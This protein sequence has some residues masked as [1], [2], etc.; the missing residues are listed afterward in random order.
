[1]TPRGLAQVFFFRDVAVPTTATL[2]VDRATSDLK[3]D[4]TGW[5]PKRAL[6]AS[7]SMTAEAA[8]SIGQ[9]LIDLGNKAAAT[10][11]GARTA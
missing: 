6:V 11:E 4:M 8:I 5:V 10:R 3:S 2:E 7:V 1:M 9:Y